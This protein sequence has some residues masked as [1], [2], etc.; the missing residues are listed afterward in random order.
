MIKRTKWDPGF[1]HDAVELKAAGEW[2][3]LHTD[4]VPVLMSYN[5]AVNFYAGNH[6]IRS[7]ATFS[8]DE[9]HRI[10]EYARYR[11]IT[12][13]VWGERYASYFPKLQALADPATAPSELV[14]VYDE[15]PA[16]LLRTIIY[17]LDSK[18]LNYPESGN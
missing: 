3:R 9:W 4:T 12:H 5:K 2:L 14:A 6:N 7:G 16:P 8:Q 17:R 15:T 18:N 13:V 1:W 10:V 11:G